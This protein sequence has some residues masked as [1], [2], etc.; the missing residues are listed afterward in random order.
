M[1]SPFTPRSDVVLRSGMVLQSD[2]IPV[3]AGPFCY[4]NA[5]DGI[6]LADPSLRAEL[7]ERYPR[8][9]ARMTQRRLFMSEVLGLPLDESV[10]P[11]TT[12]PGWLA[13]YIL[14][15]ECALVYR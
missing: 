3:S 5:E 1:H 4:L 15:P 6:A 12:I 8:C 7:A 11:L 14:I 13:P 2:I 10:L 9:W